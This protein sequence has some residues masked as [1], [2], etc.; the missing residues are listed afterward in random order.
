MATNTTFNPKINEI[1]NKIPNITNLATTTA[2]TAVKNK[3]PNVGSLSRKH[4]YNTKISE[5]ENKITTDHDPDKYITAQKINKTTSE[6]FTARLK[7]ANLASKR[8]IS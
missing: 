6:Q 7:Q 4:G 2:V 8:D 5:T 3:I 1:Q